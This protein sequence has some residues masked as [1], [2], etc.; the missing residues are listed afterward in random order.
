VGLRAPVPSLSSPLKR[1]SHIS[2][3]ATHKEQTNSDSAPQPPPKKRCLAKSV[4]VLLN[5]SVRDGVITRPEVLEVMDNLES[6]DM[7]ELATSMGEEI[8]VDTDIVGGNSASSPDSEYNPV[9][10]AHSE[11]SDDS[12]IQGTATRENEDED[13]GEDEDG[14]EEDEEEESFATQR[15]VGTHVTST[16]DKLKEQKQRLLAELTEF[17]EGDKDIR[18]KV[19]STKPNHSHF[20]ANAIP[21]E[22]VGGGSTLETVKDV[23]D[24][25][26]IG[27]APE[28]E[29]QFVI[30]ATDT[31]DEADLKRLYFLQ[32]WPKLIWFSK[33]AL[34][35][36]T[37]AEHKYLLPSMHET[38]VPRTR[39]TIKLHVHQL[40]AVSF[41]HLKRQEFPFALLHDDMGV[42][43]V[44]HRSINNLTVD[45]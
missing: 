31:D 2:S 26:T 3:S 25:D 16:G 14:D 45:Y 33:F 9:E 23:D 15:P 13:E 36:G 30:Q 24:A 34:S 37:E 6:S 27:K 5:T 44:I 40:L 41:L 17:Q 11:N 42:G 43:K 8:Y 32:I 22:G 29:E 20:D 7:E 39:D 38:H 35:Q 18:H 4:L 10:E 19:S 21:P 12:H 28:P 1:R